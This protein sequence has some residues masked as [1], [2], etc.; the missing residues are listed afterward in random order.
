MDEFL[1]KKTS[2]IKPKKPIMIVGLPGTGNVSRIVLDY[3]I[4][5]TKAKKYIEIF[6]NTFPNSVFVESDSTVRLPS[7]SV[8]YVSKS[9]KDFLFVTG[10]MQPLEEQKSYK[11][12]KFLID[13]AKK[14]NAKEIITIGG[15][16]L[17]KLPEKPKVHCIAS[18]L[19]HL[20]NLKEVGITDGNKTVGFVV[21]VSGVILG[22]SKLEK[23][24]AVSFL[25]ETHNHPAHFGIKTALPVLKSLSKYTKIN[26]NLKSIESEI[27]KMEKQIKKKS[28]AKKEIAK[29]MKKVDVGGLRYIG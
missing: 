3:L 7:V 26:I 10:D 21:G 28:I 15:I 11:L 16:G 27:N 12:S 6:S 8:Y 5:T 19:I 9:K 29:A 17:N 20:K 22:L 13:L 1:V 2:K 18:D 24:K 14:E 25:G 4:K 23:I